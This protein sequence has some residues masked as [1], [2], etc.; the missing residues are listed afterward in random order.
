MADNHLI[1]TIT[2][3][4]EI[5][6]HLQ[7]ATLQGLSAY[8]V[9]V[10]NG[11]VGTE[12]EWLASL[13]GD[14]GATPDISIG[15]VTTGQPGTNAEVSV[16]G[17]P[18]NPVMDFT[19]PRGNVGATPNIAIGTVTTG[20]EGSQAQATMTGTP[21]NPV[22]NLTIP[23]GDTGDAG[24]NP[25][26]QVTKSGNT[27]T[28][29]VTD[30]THTTEVNIVDGYTPQKNVDYF[31]G[32]TPVITGSKSQGTT[33]IYSDGEQIGA[34]ADGEDGYTPRKGVDYFDGHTPVIAGEKID[35]TTFIYADGVR[36]ATVLDGLDGNSPVIT[37]VKSGKTTSILADSVVIGTINDGADG[38]SPTITTTKSGKTT[39][40]LSDGTSIGTVTDGQDGHSPVKGTDYWTASDKASIVSDVLNSQEIS[41]INQDISDLSGTVSGKYSKPSTGIP[42]SDLASG[43]IPDVSDK[44][45]KVNGAT[46]GN[47]ASLDANGN[48]TDSGHKHSDYLTEAPVTDVQVN[49]TSVLGQDGIANIPAATSNNYGAVLIGNGLQIS[50]SNG[51]LMTRPANLSLIKTGSEAFMQITPNTQHQ[52]V[53]YG[54]AKA[55]GDITQ[56]SSSNT[57][58]NYTE[59][60]KKAI[61]AMIGVKYEEPFRLIKEITIT[62]ETL[63]LY[64]DTDS[65]GDSFALKEVIILH[66]DF[67]CTGNGGMAYLFNQ[68][69]GMSSIDVNNIPYLYLGDGAKTTAVKSVVNAF[70][71]GGRFFADGI[72]NCTNW[73]NNVYKRSCPAAMGTRACDSLTSVYIRS[74]NDH[75]MTSGTIKIYGR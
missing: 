36:I 35:D 54:L 39:T 57:V 4:E 52:S 47:F 26:A 73:Y 33:F 23:K 71:H 25:I 11:F 59:E 44:A 38:H 60:A 12:A 75:R 29:T 9:A 53:F 45:D 67:T 64:V 40:I 22:L 13:K 5:Y 41:Q 32:H 51:T 43:V 49:G 2:M 58:G 7:N 3:G 68:N 48:L 56:S 6:G 15:N 8:E 65:N 62:E 10:A 55:A 24:V 27:A 63:S 20:E 50:S 18:E 1:G 34:V 21:E 69:G 28:V 37:T 46:S 70:I 74:W 42:A 72:S 66:E 30:A 16:S 61:C 31:D 14:T 17:T 19:I